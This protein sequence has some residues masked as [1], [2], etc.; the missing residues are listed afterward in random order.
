MAIVTQA[1][2]TNT[3]IGG[4]IAETD[5][6]RFEARAEDIIAQVTRNKVTEQN[7]DTFPAAV[8]TA[9]KKAI[10]AQMEYYNLNGI[11]VALSGTSAA[12]FTVGKVSVKDGEKA[13]GRASMLCPSSAAYLEQTGLMSRS[14]GVIGEPFLPFWYGGG[15]FD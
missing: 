14:V 4:A 13:T 15:L 6:A 12:S 7:I 9:Y 3:Y 1:Y 5:F 10:C 8:Q 11:D 2:Y